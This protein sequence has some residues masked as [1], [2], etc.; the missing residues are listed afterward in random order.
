MK[1]KQTFLITCTEF[2]KGDVIVM[3]THPDK[4]FVVTKIHK[5]TW[6]RR[7]L[8]KIGFKVINFSGA[9]VKMLPTDESSV[10]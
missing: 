1:D 7:L 4:E 10:H 2:I 5:P 3:S 9:T 8:S 6:W